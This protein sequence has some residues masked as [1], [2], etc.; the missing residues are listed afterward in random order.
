MERHNSNPDNVYSSSSKAISGL[1][2]LE[3]KTVSLIRERRNSQKS[4][5]QND[6]EIC[7]PQKLNECI[8]EEKKSQKSEIDIIANMNATQDFWPSGLSPALFNSEHFVPNFSGLG[9]QNNQGIN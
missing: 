1:P 9:N 5:S 7:T 2:L 6:E 4:K 3:P 8:E